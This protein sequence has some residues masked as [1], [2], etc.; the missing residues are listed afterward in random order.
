MSNITFIWCTIVKIHCKKKHKGFLL[1]S[2][3]DM[4]NSTANTIGAAKVLT[5]KANPN[6]KL[7]FP[8][9]GYRSAREG[10][11]YWRGGS[12][13]YWTSSVNGSNLT[14]FAL[15]KSYLEMRTSNYNQPHNL[16]KTSG[17]PTYSLHFGTEIRT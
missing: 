7:T 14:R 16:G 15:G 8:A 6:V 5:S 12:G 10:N 4:D 3:G 2:L 13:E 11:L 1:C 17:F 9:T